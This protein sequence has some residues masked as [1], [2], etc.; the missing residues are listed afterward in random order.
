MSELNQSLLKMMWEQS[1]SL[2]KYIKKIKVNTF[3]SEEIALFLDEINHVNDKFLELF[4]VEDASML[5]QQQINFLNQL[6]LH[7]YNLVKS[8]TQSNTNN[9]PLEV[10]LPLRE[11]VNNLGGDPDFITEP[12]WDINYAI[13]DFWS[14]FAKVVNDNGIANVTVKKRIVTQFPIL[15]KDN[16][17]LGCIMGHELG[18]YLDLHHSFNITEQLLPIILQDKDFEKL[19]PY[20]KC[21]TAKVDDSTLL[22]VLKSLVSKVCLISW[23]KEFV[24]DIAGLILYGPSSHFSCEQ[25]FM[26]FGVSDSSHLIDSFSTTHP[27]KFT[28]SIVRNDALKKLGYNFPEKIEDII[29]E[30][31]QGWE[32][33]PINNM[34]RTVSDDYINQTFEMIFDND[35]L[36]IIDE[37]LLKNLDVIFNRVR[38]LIPQD[39]HYS[40]TL[41]NNIAI[42]LASKLSSLIPPNELNGKPSDSISILNAGWLAY[43]MFGDEIKKERGLEKDKGD[44]ELREILNNLIRKALTA[45]SIHRRWDA[46]H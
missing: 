7:F 5:N 22:M 34:E 21:K 16:V 13:G 35:S 19:L 3:P 43:Y 36:S 9:H 18:H 4:N 33:A 8:V 29:D 20:I 2:S 28:R 44:S 40:P 32:S 23:L 42:P 39:V 38:N 25:I 46:C 24:A 1:F 11:I 27:K 17:L 41:F 26:I 31:H 14:H 12:T 6:F 37:I 30:M 45:A 10:M 15:H